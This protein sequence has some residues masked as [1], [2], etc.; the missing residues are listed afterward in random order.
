MMDCPE[1]F[2]LLSMAHRSP[3]HLMA[4]GKLILSAFALQQVDPLGLIP[5]A[6]VIYDIVSSMKH[7]AL[8]FVIQIMPR[9]HEV[10]DMCVK[11]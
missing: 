9:L 4:N 1:V 3:T 5:F 8:A 7:L 6:I 11:A 2:R 10:P